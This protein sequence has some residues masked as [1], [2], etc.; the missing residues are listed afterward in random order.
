MIRHSRKIDLEKWRG[1]ID[2][3]DWYLKIWPNY[4][5]IDKH[6]AY[7]FFEQHLVAGDLC[8]AESGTNWDAERKPVD[9]IV[10][11]HT[12]NPSGMPQERLS[13][14]Q[15]FRL[16]IPRYANP[17]DSD[18]QTKGQPIW[19]GHFKNGKQVFYSYHW[20][21]RKDGS[22]ERLLND[23]EIGWH[24]GNW[25]INTRSIAICLDGDY[26]K[27]DPPQETIKAVANIIKNHYSNIETNSIHGHRD[28]NKKTDCPGGNFSNGWKKD[29][30]KL[31]Q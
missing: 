25:D 7:D 5:H 29:I 22:V 26:R 18:T 16:Y 8:L 24:A 1:Y 10:I 3:P 21:V 23:N 4:K 9:T 17:P 19:S 13:A 27:K 14:M 31:L 2:Q 12:A 28:F 20:F 6:Q 15:L 30:L 11:H